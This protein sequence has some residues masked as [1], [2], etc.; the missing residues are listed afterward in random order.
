MNRVPFDSTGD[1]PQGAHRLRLLGTGS[2]NAWSAAVDAL[3]QRIA[4]HRYWSAW[5]PSSLLE[6]VATEFDRDGA[7]V[8]MAGFIA[9]WRAL[10]SANIGTPQSRRQL[11]ASLPA[12]GTSSARRVR[13]AGSTPRTM[14]PA[15]R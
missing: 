1:A 2:A 8:Y 7:T 15:L 5:T 6:V 4:D 9:E 3:S 10:E 11:E 13:V 14:I 12:A